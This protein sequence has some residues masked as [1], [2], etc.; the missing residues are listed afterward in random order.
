MNM[1]LFHIFLVQVLKKLKTK[2]RHMW[3][4]AIA[5][6]SA[7]VLFISSATPALAYIDPVTG[8]ILIQTIIG[9]FAALAVG[10]RSVREKIISV[11]ISKKQDDD[12]DE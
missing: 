6:S 2:A 5:G 9:G 1:L 10:I 7:I 4:L 12:K 11:F 8:S 3:K